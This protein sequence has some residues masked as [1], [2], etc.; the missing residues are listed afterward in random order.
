MELQ[1]IK[2]RFGIIGN[3][4][5]LNNALGIA[6][7]VAPTDLSVLILGESGVG[8]EV[9]SQIIHTLSPRKHNAFIAV[10]CGAIP[11]GTIDSELFGHE[12]GA[13]TGASDKRKGYFEVVDK[14]TIFLDEIGEMPLGTQARLLRILESGEFMKVGSSTTQKTNVRVLAATNVD[15][16][17][18]VKRGKFR[19]DLYYRL[20]I[21]PINI[22]PLRERRE[23]IYLLF[24]KFTTDFAERNHIVSISLTPEARELLMRYSWPGNIRELKNIAEQMTVLSSEREIDGKTLLRFLP[25][26]GSQTR[27]PVLSRDAGS[28]D[29]SERD[30]F[31]KIL[32]EMREDIKDLK[33]LMIG[34]FQSGKLPAGNL[35]PP[36]GGSGAFRPDVESAQATG[37]P[38]QPFSGGNTYIMPNE[39][40]AFPSH[41]QHDDYKPAEVYEETLS[42]IDMEKELITKALQKHKGKRK[43]AALEL[44]I[45]ER[46][47]YRKIKEYHIKE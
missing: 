21:V 14:G 15:L 46:T 45:S 37:S 17:E 12:K 9:F 31:F 39:Q 16:F 27:F 43:N 2:L 32:V 38:F 25:E 20:N 4:P 1:S 34:L 18:A 13:F 26:A 28:G 42:L 23:D 8:K 35:L 11:E 19:E 30:V 33:Q 44:G 40:V 3:S 47:L 7:R 5:G 10:N 36:S 22:P 24:R 6:Q 41:S 29:F